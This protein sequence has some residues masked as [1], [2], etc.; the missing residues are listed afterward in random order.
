MDQRIVKF[1]DAIEELGL[2]AFIVNNPVNLTY[3]TGFQGLPGDGCL[4]VT[5]KTVTLITDAR[6]Q[7]ELSQSLPK[8]IDLAITRDYYQ[9][10][11]K[12]LTGP[13]FQRVGFETSISFQLYQ[14]LSQLFGDALIAE[15]GVIEKLREV[16][17]QDEVAALRK[18][19]SLA[20][21]GFEQLIK[22]VTV[23]QTERQVSNW[24]NNWM[25]D[26]GAEKPSFDTI[27]ASGYRS[28]LPHGAASNKQLAEA[29]MVTVDFG[30][31]VDHYTS[32]I[33]RTFALGDPGDQ[34]KHIHEIVYQAQ[35]KMFAVIKPGA[36]GR[37]VDA[38]GRDFIRKRGYG[39]YYEHGSGH[40]IGLDIHEGPNFGPRWQS[41][42]SAINNVMTVEPGIYLPKLGGVRIEDDLLITADGNE[43]LTTAP[44]KLIIL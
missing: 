42:I 2:D 43:R 38:A 28:A 22:H 16:K 41:N 39:K 24:L 19:T 30:F 37:D 6:Y 10:A 32:D 8:D 35:E 11:R 21:E 31:Y 15:D 4:T 1:Q 40:G 44:R 7:E 33:T 20:S 36:N 27:V 26:H 29:D 17:G 25:L 34:L 9:V 23:G 13:K 3:L 5:P 12:V 18:S 14:L